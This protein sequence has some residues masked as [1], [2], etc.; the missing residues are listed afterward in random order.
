MKAGE[1]STRVTQDIAALEEEAKEARETAEAAEE[2]QRKAEAAASANRE[3]MEQNQNAENESRDRF[4][5]EIAGWLE[6]HK[7]PTK[8]AIYNNKS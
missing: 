7:K 8:V 6:E 3:F 5:D 1:R 2:A 4:E